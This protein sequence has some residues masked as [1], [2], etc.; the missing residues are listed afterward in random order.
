MCG[1]SLHWIKERGK[2]QM[3]IRETHLTHWLFIPAM[4]CGGFVLC[5]ALL[6]GRLQLVNV[7]LQTWTSSSLTDAETTTL[8]GPNVPIN[9]KCSKTIT[10]NQNLIW[11]L[12]IKVWKATFDR[13]LHL[14]KEHTSDR[15][16]DQL[17][18]ITALFL[19]ESKLAF[20]FKR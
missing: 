19:S 10:S 11:C 13:I 16:S 17:L 18:S 8:P 5:M 14:H 4:A 3:M 12:Y 1:I 15:S 6:V 2:K 7:I 20:C 9:Q